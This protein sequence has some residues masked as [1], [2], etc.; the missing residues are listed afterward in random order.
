MDP[1]ARVLRDLLGDWH[2]GRHGSIVAFERALADRKDKPLNPIKNRIN[3]EL[4]GR[5]TWE[6]VSWVV[7]IC[8]TAATDKDTWRNEQLGSIAALWY[9]A[10]GTAPEGYLG[11]IVVDGRVARPA[12]TDWREAADAR[13][14]T[15]AL[16][17]E[18]ENSR[19]RESSLLEQLDAMRSTTTYI[20]EFAQHVR[21]QVNLMRTDTEEF[22]AFTRRQLHP[23][24]DQVTFLNAR[25]ESLQTQLGQAEI[26]IIQIRAERDGH[27]D[28]RVNAERER[29]QAR[30]EAVQ[31]SAK[32]DA[33]QTRLAEANRRL[34]QLGEQAGDGPR[35]RSEESGT[36]TGNRLLVEDRDIWFGRRKK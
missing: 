23:L 3:R 26:T 17:A 20:D 12:V 21:A 14:R 34:Q 36:R 13:T 9:K 28:G 33:T 22:R 32:L 18:L 24:W 19:T 25:V 2:G 5:P 31:L 8:C 10:R 11:D 27:Y 16:E 15:A 30:A 7:D 1:V 6:L 4:V 35:G 29:D